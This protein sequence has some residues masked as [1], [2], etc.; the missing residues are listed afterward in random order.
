MNVTLKK[1]PGSEIEI[2]VALTPA[3][4]EP[5]AKRAATLISEEVAIEGFR[6][7]KAPYDVVKARVGEHALY[8]RAAEVA[9]RATYPRAYQSLVER[10]E[11]SREHPAI[12]R[13]EVTITKLAAGNDF[14]YTVKAAVLPA[15]TLPDWRAIAKTTAAERKEEAASDEE[16]SRAVAWLAESRMHRVTVARPAAPGD[17]AEVDFEIRS[18]GVKIADG[19]SRNHPIV[20]GHA[21]FLPGF[22]EQLVGMKAGERKTFTLAVPADWRDQAVAGKMLEFS[23]LMRLVQERRIPEA[24][25]EFARDLGDFAT[26]DALRAHVSEGITLEK[27][28][29]ETQRIRGL[30]ASRI[31][32]Q[33][34]MEVP[35]IL[36]ASET[37]KMLAELRAGIADLGMT[38]EKY[39]AHIKKSE[40]EI[41][42]GWQDEARKRV[43]VSLVLREIARAEQVR[44]TEEEIKE[45]ADRLLAQFKTAAEAE[46]AVDPGELRD[47]TQGVLKNEKVFEL[48]EDKK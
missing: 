34:I 19:D 33:A 16:V 20:I 21:K 24:G 25:D 45:R 29:K 43:R 46:R 31:A 27:K 48:L 4:F 44:P 8:E 6:K 3:E 26:L 15:V 38:W 12:G 2:A 23:V 36:I 14:T 9:A 32:E 30:M 35:A 40:Q 18:D 37:E 28:E 11:L 13:P 22:E 1:L 39:L 10:G 47:Y 5:H 17:H 42:D 7:G 41:K